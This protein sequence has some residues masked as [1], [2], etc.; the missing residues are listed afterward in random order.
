LLLSSPEPV[1]LPSLVL[2]LRLL[3]WVRSGGLW[4]AGAP[5]DQPVQPRAS[6][7]VAICSAVKSNGYTKEEL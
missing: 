3:A 7:A 2:L 1:T 6:I 5:L 4:G